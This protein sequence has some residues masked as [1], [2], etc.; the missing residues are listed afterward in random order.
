MLTRDK[1]KGERPKLNLPGNVTFSGKRTLQ[2]L[3]QLAALGDRERLEYALAIRVARRTGAGE[4]EPFATRR[5]A[6]LGLATVAVPLDVA[7]SASC[8]V[9]QAG[10]H[11]Q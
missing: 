9:P 11:D 8:R 1:N 10:P 2:R 7:R 4:R 3:D 6:L 5:S